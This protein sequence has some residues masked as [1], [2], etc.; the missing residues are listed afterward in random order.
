MVISKSLPCN[1]YISDPPV[2]ESGYF[3]CP[4]IG[5]CFLVFL[6][7]FC[8]VSAF[9]KSAT[10]SSFYTDLIQGGLKLA[11]DSGGL[12]SPL[13]ICVLSGIECVIS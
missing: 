11:R 9:V 13:W 10:S 7:I 8:W 12:S 1:S 3:I 2:M 4:L 5:P 6:F